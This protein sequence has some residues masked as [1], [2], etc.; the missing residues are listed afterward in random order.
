MDI[1][2]TIPRLPQD[3]VSNRQ[4][5]QLATVNGILPFQQI[6]GVSTSIVVVEI[7]R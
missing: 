3:P 7:V 6:Q 1:A 2:E 5:D 4:V